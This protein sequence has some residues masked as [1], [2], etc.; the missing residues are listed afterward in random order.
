MT[1]NRDFAKPL[2][3]AEVHHA[4]NWAWTL[5]Q[6]GRN[7]AGQSQRIT[8]EANRLKL[9][10]LDGGPD[11]VYLLMDLKANHWGHKRFV[12]ATRGMA[13]RYGWASLDCA[14]LEMRW[15]NSA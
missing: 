10:L 7:W 11:A 3:D 6:E 5:Q 8:I 9:V 12:I 4:V 2:S 14:A 15:Q 1:H 13:D